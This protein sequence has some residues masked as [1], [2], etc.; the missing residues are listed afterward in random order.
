MEPRGNWH[1]AQVDHD[2]WMPAVVSQLL[3]PSPLLLATYPAP[4]A[5][6][7]GLFRGKSFLAFLKTFSGFLLS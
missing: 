2:P 6:T 3:L 7:V 5:A 4:L 1:I